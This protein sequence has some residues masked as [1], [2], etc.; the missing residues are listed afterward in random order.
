MGLFLSKFKEIYFPKPRYSSDLIGPIRQNKRPRRLRRRKRVKFQR[1]GKS[2]SEKRFYE[3][4]DN[5]DTF[6]RD[7]SK[8]INRIR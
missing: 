2:S 8:T 7:L 4:G 6:F 5:F 1:V 3:I